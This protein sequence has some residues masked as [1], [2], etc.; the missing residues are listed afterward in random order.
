MTVTIPAATAQHRVEATMSAARSLLAVADA[1]TSSAPTNAWD[2]LRTAATTAAANLLAATFP[3]LGVE[4]AS[5]GRTEM[6]W[7]GPDSAYLEAIVHDGSRVDIAADL[8][9]AMADT[10]AAGALGETAEWRD[11]DGTQLTDWK[12]ATPDAYYAQEE[13]GR[14]HSATIR[15]DGVT[16]L[17]LSDLTVP[18]ARAG[19]TALLNYLTAPST[20]A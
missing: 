6:V 20:T 15:P 10:V 4:A 7:H 12:T 2:A 19:L 3:H 1:A 18:D 5:V 8:P 14:E 11:D 16:T 17:S 13:D 9:T